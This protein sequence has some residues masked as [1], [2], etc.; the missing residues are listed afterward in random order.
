MR[1]ERLILVRCANVHQRDGKNGYIIVAMCID[2]SWYIHPP[3]QFIVAAKEGFRARNPETPL[4]YQI[5]LC[6]ECQEG[7]NHD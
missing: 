6:P 5:S 2:E 7:E 1:R 4:E 3:A